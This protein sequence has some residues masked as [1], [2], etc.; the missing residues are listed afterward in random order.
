MPSH[1]VTKLGTDASIWCYHVVMGVVHHGI[2]GIRQLVGM[3]IA[4]ALL[5]TFLGILRLRICRLLATLLE[6]KNEEAPNVNPKSDTGQLNG[7]AE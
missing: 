4:H 5:G 6:Q 2:S 3:L 7:Y 1:V